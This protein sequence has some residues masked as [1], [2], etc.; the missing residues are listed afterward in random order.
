MAAPAP[1]PAPDPLAP[2]LAV[3]LDRHL[4]ARTPV[5]GGCIHRA[6]R[7]TLADG[8]HL[9]AKSGPR[10][11]LPLL[12]AEADG[13]RALAAAADPQRLLV[14]APLALGEVEGQA[15]LVLPW[16]VLG[17]A[18]GE[19]GQGD[20]WRALGA[21]LAALHRRSLAG[22]LVAGDRGASAFGWV[23]DN[24]IGATPQAN[25]WLEDWG[26]FFVERRL[27]PQIDRLTRREGAL[28]GADTLLERVPQW[29]ARHRPDPCLVHG[30]LWSGNAG[31]APDG[32][33]ALFD[34]S[35]H[36]ADREVDLAMARLFGGFP[37][38]F[39]QAYETAWPLPSGHHQRRDL[40][41][42]YHRLNHANLFGGSYGPQARNSIA[43]LLKSDGRGG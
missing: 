29:L 21:A 1:D 23:R 35:V 20:R 11:A 12:E 40:Y 38:S 2:W 5:G 30:D 25:G 7:L 18:G 22:P 4:V 39:F 9:F 24:H 8:G 16:L 19:A 33:G 43:Q 41:N 32:R 6:W 36:R 14:P 26:R 10:A 15:V 13:L 3:Q 37:E 42:L 34:P 31:L 17:S 27:A 28:P